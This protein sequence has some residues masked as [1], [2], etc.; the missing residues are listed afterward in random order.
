MIYTAQSHKASRLVASEVVELVLISIGDCLLSG[1]D[2][3]DDG[4]F[5]SE[6]TVKVAHIEDVLRETRSELSLLSLR[7]DL[8][9]IFLRKPWMLE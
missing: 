9:M 5:P 2:D 7:K 4:G 8:L 6:L 3:R 1:R